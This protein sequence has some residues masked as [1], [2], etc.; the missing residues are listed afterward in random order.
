MHVVYMVVVVGSGG[1][2][3]LWCVGVTGVLL[4][5]LENGQPAVCGLLTGSTGK[6]RIGA[7]T[8]IVVPVDA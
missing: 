4:R 8:G 3:V 5:I 1:D 6:G 7:D 2:G